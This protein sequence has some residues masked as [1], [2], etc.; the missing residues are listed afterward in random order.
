MGIVVLLKNFALVTFVRIQIDADGLESSRLHNANQTQTHHL[1]N[2]QEGYNDLRSCIERREKRLKGHGFRRVQ[3]LKKHFDSVRDGKSRDFY[4]V[5]L[6]KGFALTAV[7]FL[8]YIILAFIGWK[9]WKRHY[10][11]Q[12]S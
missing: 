2:S 5:I 4:V 6:S 10:E 7:L 9:T 11:Q 3:Y 12:V 1:Q 8:S